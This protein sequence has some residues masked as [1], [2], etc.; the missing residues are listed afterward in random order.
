[1]TPTTLLR[2]YDMSQGVITVE[3]LDWTAKQ[4]AVL[5]GAEEGECLKWVISV[6]EI[7]Q[8]HGLV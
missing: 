7:L 5:S 6:F 8:K 2:V 1:M 4:V 3:T